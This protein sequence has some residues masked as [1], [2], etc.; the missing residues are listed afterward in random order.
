M[1]IKNKNTFIEPTEIENKS[2][3]LIYFFPMGYLGTLSLGATF[4]DHR[5][6]S[7]RDSHTTAGFISTKHT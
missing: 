1:I 7:T 3:I 4:T 2:E 6:P 5:D